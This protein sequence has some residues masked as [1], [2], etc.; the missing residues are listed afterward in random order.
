MNI[1]C[2][3]PVSY[4]NITFILNNIKEKIVFWKKKKN[5]FEGYFS[6][7]NM[8]DWIYNRKLYI[9]LMLWDQIWALNMMTSS[10]GHFPRYWPFVRVTGE[11]P[12]QRPVMRSFHVFLDLRSYKRLSKQWWGWWFETPSHS[13]WHHCNAKIPQLWN[14]NA[15]QWYQ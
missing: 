2:I 9:V 15:M 12:A 8:P 7:W 4:K 11:F 3:G 5:S 6:S 10:N 1:H 13:L 14:I